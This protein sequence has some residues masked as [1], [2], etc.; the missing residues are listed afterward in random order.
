M[1]NSS[2]LVHIIILALIAVFIA[3][4]LRSVLG[5]RTGNERPPGENQSRWGRGPRRAD[6]S[7]GTVIDL[8]NRR[9]VWTAQGD[10]SR[11]PAQGLA[12]IAAQEPGFSPQ[13]FLAG[14][15]TAFGMIV[16]AFA[17][18]DRA[19][20][21]PLVS[22]PVFAGFD[23][24]IAERERAQAANDPWSRHRLTAI[25]DAAIVAAGIQGSGQNGLLAEITVRFTSTQLVSDFQGQASRDSQDQ[26]VDLWT[27]QRPLRSSD[28]TWTLIATRP[29]D[30]SPVEPSADPLATKH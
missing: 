5:S 25:N 10:A 22:D 28:P 17:A 4:R 3:L 13:A 30:H 29:V 8:T 6:Q 21:R 12:A 1:G 7:D 26:V 11:E 18:G 9:G 14:A 19:A 24:A 20:L 15:Q 27:F 2:D 16:E 23:Q